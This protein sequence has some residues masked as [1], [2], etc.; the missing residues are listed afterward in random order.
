MK[1]LNYIKKTSILKVLNVKVFTFALLLLVTCWNF[2]RPIMTFVNA[3]D[4]PVSWCVF[5]FFMT[6]TS[7]LILFWFGIVYINTDIPFMQHVNMYQVIRTGRRWWAIGQ[8][9]GIFI[10]ALVVVLFTALCTILPLI[11]NIELTNEWGKLLRTAAMTNAMEAYKFDYYIYYDIFSEFT[12]LQLMGIM[13][14]LC[15]LICAFMGIFMFFVCLYTNKILAV[16]GA[17]ALSLLTFLVINVHPLVRQKFAL[18]IPTIWVQVCKIATRS[19]GYYWLP[20]ISYMLIF[21]IVG[22]VIMTFLILCK[23][24]KIEFNWVNED[25]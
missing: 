3:V 10:R 4:Y 13:I 8:I 5:P 11:P 16:T 7:F 21:L 6:S 9:G 17:A 14:L 12:P 19:F 23:V 15:T 22:I 18:I 25:I 1:I 20:S 24:K 2:N